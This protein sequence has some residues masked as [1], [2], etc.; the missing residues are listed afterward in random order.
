MKKVIVFVILVVSLAGCASMR[1]G[2]S[3][4]TLPDTC[5]LVDAAQV[6]GCRSLCG[7]QKLI[8]TAVCRELCKF[9]TDVAEVL[10]REQL[11]HADKN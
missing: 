10:I 6:A 1:E 7:K 8:D 3:Q 9:T 4:D 5:Q 2:I 11:K